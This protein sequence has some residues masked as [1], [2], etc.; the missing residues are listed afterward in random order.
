MQD[1]LLTIQNLGSTE[2][3]IVTEFRR[4]TIKFV[5]IIVF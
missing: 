3:I 4:I 5:K 1:I 2:E